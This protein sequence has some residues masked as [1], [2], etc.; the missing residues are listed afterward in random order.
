MECFPVSYLPSQTQVSRRVLV[1][2]Q[3]H[4][5]RSQTSGKRV[6]ECQLSQLKFSASAVAAFYR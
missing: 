1:H 5:L 6:T 2:L 4:L 3:A